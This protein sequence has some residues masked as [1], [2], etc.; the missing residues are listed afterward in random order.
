MLDQLLALA[1][2]EVTDRDRPGTPAAVGR[3]DPDRRQLEVPRGDR[4]GAADSARADARRHARLL[5]GP[6]RRPRRSRSA[7]T[8]R[9]VRVLVTGAYGLR[10]PPP[11][12]RRWRPTATSGG[13]CSAERPAL[14]GQAAL[15]P[16]SIP[17]RPRGARRAVVDARSPRWSSIWPALSH[18]GDSWKHIADYFRVNVLGTEN[19]LAAAARRRAAGLARLERRGLRH[20]AGGRA[21][22][23]RGRGRS[24]PRSPYALT[25]AAAERHGA[26]AAARW[27]CA[28]FNLI[29]AG[30]GDAASPCRR[31]PSSSPRSRG[32]PAEPVLAVGNLAARRDFVHVATP[33]TAFAPGAARASR[34]RS[35]TSRAAT[36]RSIAE[37]STR[38]IASPA[39][40]S[41]G[42]VDPDRLRPVD[43]P[44]LWATPAACAPSAGA[45]AGVSSRRSRA[46]GRGADGRSGE[47]ED[48]GHRGTGFLGRGW[49]RGW[50][51]DHD[52]SPCWCAPPRRGRVFPSGDSPSPQ[53]TSPTAASLRA[54]PTAATPSSTPR[55]WSRSPRRRARST[56]STSRA[57]KTSWRAAE[58]ARVERLLYVSSFMALG[59]TEA[60]PAAPTTSPPPADDR[61]WIN[62]YERTKTQADRR[63][64]RAIARR[65]ADRGL[66]G[67]DLRPRRAHRRQHPGAPRSRP[68]PR[69]LPALLGKARAA[70]ELRLRRRRGRGDAPS[71]RPRPRS[72]GGRRYV[73]GRRERHP[74]RV[75]PPGRRVGRHPGADAPHARP[76]GARSPARSMKGWAR[77]S[78]G[79]LRSSPP[80]W[81]RSTATTGRSIRRAAPASTAELVAT[82]RAVAW[83][84][85]SGRPTSSWSCAPSP[86]RRALTPRRAGPQAGPH[87]GRGDRLR[88]A[89]AGAVVGRR[90]APS[91][92]I[93]FNLLR[94]AALRRPALWRDGEAAR[95]GSLGI[96]LYPMAVLLLILFYRPAWRSRRRSGAS[97]PSA[98]AWPRSSAWPRARQAALE[99]GQELGRNLAYFVFG[100]A[101]GGGV[102]AVDGAPLRQRVRARSSPSRW[103]AP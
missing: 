90:C 4:L 3:R 78:S 16:R 18:V 55:R 43:L 86:R 74:G 33:R 58:D 80:T 15:L 101:G 1:D 76:R 24:A 12:S 99:P 84:R 19:L 62:H 60:P 32:A 28:R 41:R 82:D 56:G 9:P 49:W 47:H 98:T 53:A 96:V 64:R 13:T 36:A 93:V 59:P 42:A 77:R 10:R 31:S 44:L 35:T 14:A 92:A 100:S 89:P 52:L 48:P 38:L 27:W 54:R 94:P 61:G 37:P 40:T 102:A 70:L 57:S 95:G 83:P 26:A 87:G 67:R 30:A 23:P 8:E 63:A 97:S 75:L 17:A 51:D 66:S 21:T 79:A 68:G 34:G 39:S 22:H 11:G 88:P 2:V 69:R 71:R 45:R 29:G 7:A 91:A 65:A 46:L 85:G 103:P 25:K 73:L 6:P 5:A 50:R 20:G 72:A 81:W